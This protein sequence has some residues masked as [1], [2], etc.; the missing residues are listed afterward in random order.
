MSIYATLWR[1]R[2]PRY[3]DAHTGCEWED[4]HAQAIPE[5]IEP[6]HH[7]ECERGEIDGAGYL[8][9]VFVTD[10]TK[11][12]PP[13]AEPHEYVAPLLALSGADYAAVTFDR[14]RRRICDALR[15]DRPR[16]LGEASQADG[17]VRVVYEDG[18]VAV[19]DP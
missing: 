6:P 15:G 19:F 11:I 7:L 17:R 5:H 12:G 1:L 16:L 8:A 14:L 4:V 10:D 9:V 3:G 2:F 13:G 18:S